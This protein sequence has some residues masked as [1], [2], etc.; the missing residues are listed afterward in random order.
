MFLKV[1]SNPA[2]RA[3]GFGGRLNDASL[4]GH[5]SR[6]QNRAHRLRWNRTASVTTSTS[7]HRDWQV[8]VVG[9]RALVGELADERTT[10]SAL[11]NF[12]VDLQF[13]SQVMVFW[14]GCR[15]LLP[16]SKGPINVERPYAS[17]KADGKKPKV[18]WVSSDGA[19]RTLPEVLLLPPPRPYLP[20]SNSTHPLVNLPSVC[21]RPR[22]ARAARPH[23]ERGLLLRGAR[24]RFGRLRVRLERGPRATGH[25]GGV[26]KKL[27]GRSSPCS[28]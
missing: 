5:P 1:G 16:Q 3:A 21:G 20:D 7:G 8:T 2:K 4:C 10:S 11:Y 13:N 22:P 9:G 23:P 14:D 19:E 24:L 15:L 26:G 28:C 6:A 12:S 17:S 25:C 27:C 18:A